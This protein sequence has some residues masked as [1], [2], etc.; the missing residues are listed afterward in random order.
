MRKISYLFLSLFCTVLVI[1][2][3][4]AST[5]PTTQISITSSKVFS[6]VQNESIVDDLNQSKSSSSTSVSKEQISK[7][8]SAAT[9]TTTSA[10]SFISESNSIISTVKPAIAAST[11]DDPVVYKTKT[12][13]KYHR[14]GCSYLS[15]SK[16]PIKLSEAKSEELTPCSK[17]SPPQ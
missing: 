2:G 14:D 16:I 4:N 8:T 7:I 15:K 9:I 10:N 5:N 12:G 1:T 3:C 13:S 17:C 6:S 11:S